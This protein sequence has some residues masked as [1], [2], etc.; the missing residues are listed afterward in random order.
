MILNSHF[1]SIAYIHTLLSFRL[2]SLSPTHLAS[3]DL[4]TLDI[5]TCLGE[6]VPFLFDPKSTVRYESIGSAWGAVWEFIGS[7]MVSCVILLSDGFDLILDK[8]LAT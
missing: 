2:P 7:E 4:E 8:V 6:L 1:C 3:Q 5:K